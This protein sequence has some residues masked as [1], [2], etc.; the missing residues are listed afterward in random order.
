MQQLCYGLP[1]NRGGESQQERP[2]YQDEVP[3]CLGVRK[4]EAT[5]LTEEAS[6]T[7]PRNGDGEVPPRD[8]GQSG[9]GGGFFL[10]LTPARVEDGGRGVEPPALL[11]GSLNIGLPPQAQHT[12]QPIWR[13]R[14]R[15]ARDLWC[16]GAV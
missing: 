12:G 7:V 15:G 11:E 9:E 5:D 1:A 6:G 10:G 3:G 14:R 13:V 2:G 4:G 8:N 16:V